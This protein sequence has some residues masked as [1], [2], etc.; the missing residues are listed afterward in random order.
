MKRISPFILLVLL[1]L[2][3]ASTGTQSL[4]DA[5][6]KS[7]TAGDS[8][9]KGIESKQKGIQARDAGDDEIAKAAF[10]KASKHFDEENKEVRI[11]MKTSAF[12][13]RKIISMSGFEYAPKKSFD[14][15]VIY[16]E[17]QNAY[18]DREMSTLRDLEV[19]FNAA[20]QEVQQAT[21]MEK[22][23][24]LEELGQEVEE[25]SDEIQKQAEE[26]IFEIYPTI[27]VVKKGDTLPSIAARHEIYNDSYMWPLVYKAN[28]DQIKDPKIIY[29]GQDL[30][31]PREMTIEEI[32]EARREAGAPEPEKI[33]KEAFIPRRKK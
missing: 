20:Y 17:M 30:K 27:Y 8:S 14:L 3:C 25:K 7:A 29:V 15:L 18:I 24:H 33:P 4:N 5:D 31:I 13:L 21:V 16:L 11:L 9:E 10:I 23:K 28:R 12:K 2:G 1:F 26:D 22:Q 32:I 19:Q 6:I